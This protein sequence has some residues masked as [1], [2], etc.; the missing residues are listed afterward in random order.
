MSDI[1]ETKKKLN[2]VSSSFCLAK[3]T[4]VTIHLESGTTHSCHHPAVHEISLEELKNNPSALH[5]TQF[6][7]EQRK[8]MLAGE[9]PAECE[10]GGKI[11]DLKTNDICHFKYG[12]LMAF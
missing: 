12:R 4:D 11:E 6:K 3:W 9:R 8:K 5:N 10:Y 2:A 7:I 1:F